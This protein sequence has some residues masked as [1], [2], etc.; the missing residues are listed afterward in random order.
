MR[1]RLSLFLALL[2]LLLAP[3]TWAAPPSLHAFQPPEVRGEIALKQT[4]RHLYRAI[5]ETKNHD[6]ER[7]AVRL[8]LKEENIGLDCSRVRNRTKELG[9]GPEA[10][11]Q[12]LEEMAT[13]LREEGSKPG[14]TE[15]YFSYGQEE[16][17]H[18]PDFLLFTT[19]LAQTAAFYGGVVFEIDQ[20]TPR[21]LDLQGV[22]HGLFKRGPG[23]LREWLQSHNLIPTDWKEY[24]IP[25]H[26]EAKDVVAVQLRA[27]PVTFGSEHLRIPG[28]K[29]RRYLR[30]ETEAGTH[31]EILGRGGKLRGL[32][33]PRGY[34]F[35][36]LEGRRLGRPLHP[37]LVRWLES[38]RVRG[39]PLEF[40]HPKRP[41]ETT[42]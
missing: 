36:S 3:A 34:A 8:L 16:I 39:E 26:I 29:K 14:F 17:K 42:H 5:A 1:I 31:I 9:G 10:R 11:K 20:E 2:P 12:A 37:R 13:W 24:V 40:F 38:I 18:Y 22:N 35:P 28:R 27:E 23:G 7:L 4:F 6:L 30:V 21:G 32:L 25:S 33:A 41:P 19:P 15:K